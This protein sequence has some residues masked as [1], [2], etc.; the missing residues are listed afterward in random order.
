MTLLLQ[1]AANKNKDMDMVVDDNTIRT[2]KKKEILCRAKL[3]KLS[4]KASSI[5]KKTLSSRVAHGGSSVENDVII[6]AKKLNTVLGDLLSVFGHAIESMEKNKSFS[7]SAAT[8]IGAYLSSTAD[9][10]SSLSSALLK[11]M[12]ASSGKDSFARSDYHGDE[13]DTRPMDS[14]R[15]NGVSNDPVGNATG[16]G[17]DPEP[18]PYV[19]NKRNKKRRRITR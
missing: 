3:S 17:E 11:H 19:L 15:D 8:E 18:G 4:S 7:A 1:R 9:G 2:E 5:A 10:I 14:N 13:G 12:G 6:N 16:T